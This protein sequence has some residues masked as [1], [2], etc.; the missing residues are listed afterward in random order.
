MWLRFRRWQYLTPLAPSVAYCQ[1][2]RT[3]RCTGEAE[4]VV[5]VPYAKDVEELLNPVGD[6]ESDFVVAWEQYGVVLDAT[7]KEVPR[8]AVAAVT[9]ATTGGALSPPPQR[10]T[11]VSQDLK[12]RGHPKRR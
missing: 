10:S 7:G 2:G 11:N 6:R 12:R 8:P 4:G 3:Y 9:P 1:S 5:D